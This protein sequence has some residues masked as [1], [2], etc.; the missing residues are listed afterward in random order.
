MFTLKISSKLSGFLKGHSCTSASLEM[1]EYWRMHLDEGKT[2]A[3]VAVDLSK[4]FD[5]LNQKLL[6]AKFKADGFGAKALSLIRSYFIGA[7]E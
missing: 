3:V 7:K 6:I 4:A 1:S 5:S 2:V